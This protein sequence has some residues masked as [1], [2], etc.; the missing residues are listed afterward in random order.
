MTKQQI[1]LEYLTQWD[2]YYMNPNDPDYYVEEARS[3]ARR[4]RLGDD[5]DKIAEIMARV[6]IPFIEPEP[7]DWDGCHEYAMYIWVDLTSGKGGRDDP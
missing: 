1:V 7:F 6:L 4:I 3:I 2:P 5:P